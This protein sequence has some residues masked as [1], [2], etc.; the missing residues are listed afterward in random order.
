MFRNQFLLI[1]KD[2]T[3]FEIYFSLRVLLFLCAARNISCRIQ[4]IFLSNSS[5]LKKQLS[6]ERIDIN[7]TSLDNINFV[8]FN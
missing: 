8:F 1:Q 3:V 2:G 6:G 7:Y 4:I 5:T